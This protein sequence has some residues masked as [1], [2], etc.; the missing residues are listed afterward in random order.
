VLL[1]DAELRSSFSSRFGLNGKDD[2]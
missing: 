2:I 1:N